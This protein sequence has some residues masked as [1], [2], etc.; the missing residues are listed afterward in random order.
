M[1]MRWRR[2]VR[3]GKTEKTKNKY[4]DMKKTTKKR[5]RNPLTKRGG[6]GGKSI[7]NIGWGEE[8]RF[9]ANRRH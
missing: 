5:K 1:T 8:Y 3:V 2:L 4:K 9:L 6:R 7:C